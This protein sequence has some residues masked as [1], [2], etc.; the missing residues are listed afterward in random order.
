MP[1]LEG[2]GTERAEEFP[3]F[4][5]VGFRLIA[6]LEFSWISDYRCRYPPFRFGKRVGPLYI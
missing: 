6:D 2:K 5:K 4:S 1:G 3:V